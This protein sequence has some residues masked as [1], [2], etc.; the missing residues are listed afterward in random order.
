MTTK[1]WRNHLF[2]LFVLLGVITGGTVSGVLQAQ[3]FCTWH[4]GC[5]WWP[6]AP[7]CEEMTVMCENVCADAGGV[8]WTM[9]SCI[10][11]GDQSWGHC[12][13]YNPW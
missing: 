9:S 1:T 6:D 2:V 12:Q 13:C 11:E 4:Q 8:N 3:V 10:Q 7:G 5:N